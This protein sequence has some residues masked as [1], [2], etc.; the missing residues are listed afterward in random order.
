MHGKNN[1]Q[2]KIYNASLSR[3]FLHL[4]TT[5]IV[6]DSLLLTKLICFSQFKPSLM[7]IPKN[8]VILTIYIVI[9]YSYPDIRSCIPFYK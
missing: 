3:I 9:I 8:L 4:P 7:R 6:F 2:Y 1:V 5:D